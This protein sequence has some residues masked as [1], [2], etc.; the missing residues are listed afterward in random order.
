MGKPEAIVEDYLIQEVKKI[1]GFTRK[2]V[3]KGRRGA[4][5]RLVFTYKRITPVECKS[6]V[7]KLETSQI[8]E[9]KRMDG[10]GIDNRVVSNKVH[11]DILVRELSLWR[12][13]GRI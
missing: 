12:A 11:V 4:L 13:G 8:R 2:V 1:G 10:L 6:E 9:M 5:D 7:G 3:Y